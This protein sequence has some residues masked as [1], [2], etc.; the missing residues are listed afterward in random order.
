MNVQI[1]TLGLRAATYLPV[2]QPSVV[3]NLLKLTVFPAVYH[4]SVHVRSF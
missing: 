3:T 4:L 2:T 1:V